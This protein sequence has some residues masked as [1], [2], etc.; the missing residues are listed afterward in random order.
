MASDIEGVPLYRLTLALFALNHQLEEGHVL[1]VGEVRR[2]VLDGTILKWLATDAFGEDGP[3]AFF[4]DRTELQTNAS[5]IVLF[6]DLVGNGWGRTRGP[7]KNGTALVQA[8]FIEAVQQK[9]P[10]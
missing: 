5:L 9:F 3:F 4:L 7:R 1:D 2:R 10:P 8:F 6:Q